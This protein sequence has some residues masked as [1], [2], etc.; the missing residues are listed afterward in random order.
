[1][2]QYISST[3]S[4]FTRMFIDITA[5]TFFGTY[6][7]MIVSPPMKRLQLHD[8]RIVRCFKKHTLQH[9]KSNG[10]FEIADSLSAKASYPPTKEMTDRMEQFDDQ[11]GRAIA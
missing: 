4:V 3:Y 11:L 10:M 6:M 2:C 9:L 5:N 7:Y 1:M 8:S